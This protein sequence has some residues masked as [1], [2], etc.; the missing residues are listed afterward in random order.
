M[1]DLFNRFFDFLVTS[2]WGACTLL[3]FGLFMIYLVLKHPQQDA[4]SPLQ[5]DMRGWV[6]GIVSII[7]A[8][9]IIIAKLL[10]KL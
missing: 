5:G 4:T 3:I 8:F 7:G 9:F 6:A 1:D 10:G 2:Y